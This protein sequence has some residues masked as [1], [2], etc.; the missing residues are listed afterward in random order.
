VFSRRHDY[1]AGMNHLSHEFMIKHLC[2]PTALVILGSFFLTGCEIT[3]APGFMGPNDVPA[4]PFL[5]ASRLQYRGFSLPRPENSYWHAIVSEQTHT[6]AIFRRV[7][8]GRTHTAFVSVDLNSMPRPATSP[9]DFA[10]LVRQDQIQNTNRF[11][12]ESYQHHPTTIQGQWAIEFEVTIR[13]SGAANSPG[14]PLT[15]RTSGYVVRH[16]TFPDG[17][18]VIRFSERGMPQEFDPK[19]EAEAKNIIQGVRLESSPG[20]PLD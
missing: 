10:E 8:S 3:T 13:D 7:L 2:L 1:D 18:V 20:H 19:V 11:V 9:D 6:H 14:Q 4:S 12:L 15:L 17:I 16:P 5:M